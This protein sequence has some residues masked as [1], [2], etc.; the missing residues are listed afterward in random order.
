MSGAAL[1]VTLDEG[2]W[3]E[4]AMAIERLGN[5]NKTEFFD[6]IGEELENI[7]RAAFGKKADPATGEAWAPW[8]EDY[9]ASGRHGSDL[10]HKRGDLFG[11]IVHELEPNGVVVGSDMVY[12]PTHQY[13]AKKGAFGTMKN[14]SPI[15][16]GNISARPFLGIPADFED[17]ILGD[18]AVLELLGWV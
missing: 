14:G 1:V 3:H 15:P 8:S 11:S 7:A 16:W 5:G 2:L 17:R 10:L 4:A 18:P 13:G 9:A 6:F 12:A